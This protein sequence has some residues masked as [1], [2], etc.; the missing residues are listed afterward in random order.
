MKG[1]R[2]AT[3]GEGVR[4]SE[5]A[6]QAMMRDA[7][8]LTVIS[9]CFANVERAEWEQLVAER[10]WAE[11][12][13]D[14]R[15]LTQ[16]GRKL[17]CDESPVKRLKPHRPLQDAFSE[18]EVRALFVPPT[19]EEKRSF[20]ARHFT[21]GLPESAMPVESLYTEWRPDARGDG[22]AENPFPRA[23]GLYLADTAAYM[24][25]EITAMGGSVPPEFS[26]CPDHLS[27]ELDLAAVLLRSSLV[28][29]AR[30]FVAERFAWLT[31]YRMRLLSL[32]DDASFYI[33]LVDVLIAVREQ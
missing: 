21:G 31:A 11:F 26:A 29:E 16:A 14:V 23:K 15:E 17:G 22:L 4:E 3:Q 13:D 19:Y 20:A 30:R 5:G 8:M 7:A 1:A 9:R 18:Q 2:D 28:A 10:V 32:H 6:K 12:L 24:A 25:D 27:L 33:A